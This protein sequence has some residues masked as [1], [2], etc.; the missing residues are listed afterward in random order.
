[1]ELRHLRYFAAVAELGSFTRAAQALLIAQPP[2]SKQVRDLEA[3][4]GVPLLVRHLRGV[5]LTPAGAAVLEGAREI[6][7]RAERLKHAVADSTGGT[8]GRLRVGFI[9]SASHFL[10]PQVLI[11][12][13]LQSPQIVVDGREMLSTE[14]IA[15]LQ[16]GALDVAIVRPPLRAK[17]LFVAAEFP[18]S[19]CLAVPHHHALARAGDVRP[20]ATAACDFVT[21]KRDHAR[22]FF[23]QTVKFC[24]EAGFSPNIRFEVGTIYGVLDLVAAGAGVAIVPASAASAA[25]EQVVLR[26]LTRPSRPGAIMVV[27]RRIDRNP[28]VASF[29]ALVT[30][31]F[32]R[33][34]AVVSAK[35]APARQ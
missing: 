6:L 32:T 34:Q 5:T 31:A 1:M 21:F 26:R 22:A 2:L 27:C 7:A 19:F 16:T 4:I 20:Q 33:L 9:P 35:L 29:V 8:S 17:K 15:A 3:E 23:D 28:A 18:D 12:L 30:K 14:Q 13:R 10:L 24:T 11:P 25:P